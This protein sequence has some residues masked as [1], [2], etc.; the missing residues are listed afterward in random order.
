MQWL[1]LFEALATPSAEAALPSLGLAFGDAAA[2]RQAGGRAA[3]S[4]AA[5]LA[6]SQPGE[7]L[8]AVNAVLSRT[9]AEVEH[10]SGARRARRLFALADD[11]FPGPAEEDLVATWDH[12]LRA[13][14]QGRLRIAGLPAAKRD[15]VVAVLGHYF[16]AVGPLD[17]LAAADPGD[18]DADTRH[19]ERLVA[20]ARWRRFSRACRALGKVLTPLERQRMVAAAE[21]LEA[22][23]VRSQ[24]VDCWTS[25][26]AHPDGGTW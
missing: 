1:R 18:T 7:V 16:A 9:Y 19:L 20:L 25:T 13:V 11:G 21:Q 22:R 8:D 14:H 6:E 4:L 2:L 5:I 15:V 26:G 12:A 17:T 24:A 23:P 3:A 10:A